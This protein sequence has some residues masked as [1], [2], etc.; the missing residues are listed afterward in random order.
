[1]STNIYN[2]IDAEQYQEQKRQEI[3][4]ALD[5]SFWDFIKKQVHILLHP[6]LVPFLFAYQRGE[7]FQH[8][9]KALCFGQ[10]WL[11]ILG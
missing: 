6:N 2:Q 3:Q 5:P 1:M 4:K 8:Q 10:L 9:H 11:L 7:A